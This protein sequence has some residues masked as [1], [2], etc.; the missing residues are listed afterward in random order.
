ME[1]RSAYRRNKDEQMNIIRIV[2]TAMLAAALLFCLGMITATASGEGGSYMANAAEDAKDHQGMVFIPVEA[3]AKSGPDTQHIFEIM[4]CSDECPDPVKSVVK[5]KGSGT[6]GFMIP[7]ENAGKFEYDVNVSSSGEDGMDTK[8]V[9]GYHVTVVCINDESGELAR[10]VIIEDD[11]G[12]KREKISAA[13]EQTDGNEKESNDRAERPKD[14]NG[15]DEGSD[16]DPESVSENEQGRAKT[17][18]ETEYILALVMMMASLVSIFIF[19]SRKG[20]RLL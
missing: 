2:F 19:S 10:S 7:A 6:S 12:E 4:K 1:Q 20:G 13:D 5:I 16:P 14:R 8:E 9:A 17:G 18:D 11:S 15:T 3:R